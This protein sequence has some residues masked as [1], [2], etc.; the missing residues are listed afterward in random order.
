MYFS[1]LA[2]WLV[3]LIYKCLEKAPEARFRN[4][5][6][7]HDY[8]S[9][10]RIYTP[11]VAGLVKNED[12]KWKSVLAE[13]EYEMQDLRAIIARQ[14]KELQM[15]RQKA[16]SGTAITAPAKR[17]T[18]S[19]SAFSAMMFVLL[20]VGVLAVYGLFFN[21]T[22]VGSVNAENNEKLIDDSSRTSREQSGMIVSENRSAAKKTNEKE[23]KGVKKELKADNKIETSSA[24]ATNE[25]TPN[26]DTAETQQQTAASVDEAIE[27]EK[28]GEKTS[29]EEGNTE[30]KTVQYKVRNKAY[31]HNEPDAG[32]RRN[33]FI[34]HWNNAVLKP[35]DE[36]NGFVYIVFTNHLGQVSK[37]WLSKNDLI[38]VK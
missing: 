3:K 32:T 28:Q 17:S 16:A 1:W 34:V 4:G 12:E 14:D 2:D 33:A 36:K 26:K 27:N 10:H 15:M 11:E 8:I 22:E 25:N 20:L 13:K 38:E 7:L 5:A 6:E 24:K 31:F 21:R 9:L 29:N 23:S 37:G 30:S 35:Q 18:V 19:R